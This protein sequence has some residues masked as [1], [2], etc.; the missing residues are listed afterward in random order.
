[1][2]PSGVF[3]GELR[4]EQLHTL[5][6][7]RDRLDELPLYI[8]KPA[9][10]ID[11]LHSKLKRLEIQEGVDV[12]VV[13]YMQL[14]NASTSYRSR[15]RE[16]AEIS[17]RLKDIALDSDVVV[18][19]LSQLN[20]EVENRSDQ[21]PRMADL[22]SSGAIEQDADV[23]SLLYRPAY[24]GRD[25]DPELIFAK[26]RNGSTGTVFLEWSGEK[27]QFSDPPAVPIS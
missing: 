24:Y 25:G 18:M 14:L 1:V 19:A 2:K 6:Q 17:H 15:Q 16:I 10:N 9:P 11:K 22:R 27:M 23:V 4:E 20:R 8:Q 3:Q 7:Q 21:R 12:V 13:D 26:N 5:E